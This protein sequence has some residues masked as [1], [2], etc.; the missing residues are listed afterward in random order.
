MHKAQEQVRQFAREIIEAPTSPARPE[1]RDASLRARLIVEEAAE[2][3]V[4]LVGADRARDMLEEF[5]RRELRDGVEPDLVAVVDGLC[6][7][8][9]VAY[10][11][12]EAVGIDLEL[13]FDAVHAANMRKTGEAIDDHGKKGRKP[14]GWVPPDAEIR[15]LLDKAADAYATPPLPP[16]IEEDARAACP[17]D[18]SDIADAVAPLTIDGED[19]FVGAAVEVEITVGAVEETVADLAPTIDAVAEFKRVRDGAIECWWCAFRFLD[20]ELDDGKCPSCGALGTIVDASVVVVGDVVEVVAPPV[21]PASRPESL[22][23]RRAVVEAVE[24]E[25]REERAATIAGERRVAALRAVEDAARAA[26]AAGVPF[27]DVGRAVDKVYATPLP[28]PPALRAV[29]GGRDRCDQRLADV[30]GRAFR[31]GCGANVFTEVEP[32][33]YSCNGCGARYGGEART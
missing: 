7:L 18:A 1:V 5:A 14:P 22:A 4:A 15:R 24:A 26:Q 9:Y 28:P 3:A 20:A 13:Y 25:R 32:L 31:C 12:A 19:A 27:D 11:T 16:T 6:D 23:T 8:I 33:R 30:D 29:G 21:T 10:G 17:R 2:T